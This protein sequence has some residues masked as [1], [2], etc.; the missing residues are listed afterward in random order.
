MAGKHSSKIK[1]KKSKKIIILVVLIVILIFSIM[2]VKIYTNMNKPKE[3]INITFKAIKEG[4]IEEAK[5]YIDYQKLLSIMDGDILKE[6]EIEKAELDK[7][8]FKELSWNIVNIKVEQNQAIAVV[9]IANKDYKDII[10]KWLKKIIEEK[11]KGNQLSNELCLEKLKECVTD[12]DVKY[13][14]IIK[15]VLLKEENDVWQIIVNDD[16]GNAL[17]PGIESVNSVLSEMK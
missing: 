14:T 7:E 2:V 13:R 5:K 6:E 12:K 16:L 10:T 17:F 4:N 8:L 15:K 1:K 9:E 3:T 11:S